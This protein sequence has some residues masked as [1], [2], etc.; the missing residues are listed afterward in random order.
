MP[1]NVP[2]TH[3]TNMGTSRSFHGGHALVRFP[4][5]HLH[6]ELP[7]AQLRASGRV[8][9]LAGAEVRGKDCVLSA[10]K[11]CN[12]RS[13]M[14]DRYYPGV[15]ISDDIST[16][17]ARVSFLQSVYVMTYKG[18]MKHPHGTLAHAEGLAALIV[19][20]MH[21]CMRRAQIMLTKARM[22]LNIKRIY[23]ADGV[24]VRE[25]LKVASLLYKATEKA[26]NEEEVSPQAGQI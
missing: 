6:G 7:L 25:L 24:A 13:S 1:Y 8:P 4:T 14:P 3:R 21:A 9:V 11:I 12:L 23:A 26:T 2:R 22:K 16:E 5:T 10:G 15:D 18:W 19:C 17:T 20:P